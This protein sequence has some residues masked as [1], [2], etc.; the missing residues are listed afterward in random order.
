MQPVITRQAEVIR[1]SANWPH[2]TVPG[3]AM[4]LDD[5]AVLETNGSGG[6]LNEAVTWEWRMGLAR[7]G[8]P[9]RIYL[10]DDLAL[11]DFPEHGVYY[12]PNLFRVDA[13]RLALLRRRVFRNGHVVLWGPGSGISD[14]RVIGAESA[15]QL[16]GFE[17]EKLMEANTQRRTLVSDFAHPITAELTPDTVIGGPIAY[18]PV[19]FPSDGV[20][21][22]MAWTRQGL[23]R[24][25]LAVK[26][27]GRGARGAGESGVP[28]GAGDWA[29]VFTTA[30]PIPAA[31]WRGLAR[32]A[33]VH[34]YSDEN[35]IVMADC[36]VVAVHSIRSG[37]K[38][39]RLPGTF[40]VTDLVTGR[41]MPGVTS[42]LRFT[43]EAPATRVFLLA[44]P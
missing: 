7:C 29:S 25:G 2:G 16:T 4:I 8:V 26:A 5:T 39:L 31:M 3:I 9:Y 43:M 10:F 42:E 41:R 14:G 19:L 22:G 35:D 21:L 44:A 27:F 23:R 13:A 33:G 38:R 24:S 18:G 40:A 11:D 36:S 12:F 30:V 15:R 6:F 32:Y 28:L 20:S 37:E 1:Q 17:F 34:V